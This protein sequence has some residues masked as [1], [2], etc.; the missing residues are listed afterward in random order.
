MCRIYFILEW[1]N[2]CDTLLHLFGFTIEIIFGRRHCERQIHGNCSNKIILAYFIVNRTILM[3]K[4]F[5]N[6]EISMNM[7]RGTHKTC[8][9]HLNCKVYYR[10]LHLK[11]WCN[12]AWCWLQAVWG[13]HDSVETCSSV[14][15]CEIIVCICWSCYK[16][17]K[18]ARHRRGNKDNS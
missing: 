7:I 9:K 11:Y 13:W 12:L 5:C 1:Q 14:V 15:I 18:D 8:V 10:Q 17:I 4:R 2:K 6:I 16:I 3:F